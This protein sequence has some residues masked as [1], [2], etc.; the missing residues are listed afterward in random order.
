MKRIILEV[1]LLCG[2]HDW[3]SE[4]Y[5]NITLYVIRGFFIFFK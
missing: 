3:V 4:H 2:L 1:Q 5:D